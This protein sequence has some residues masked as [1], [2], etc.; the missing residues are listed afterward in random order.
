MGVVQHRLSHDIGK[1]KGYKAGE[2]A[3]DDKMS[4]VLLHTFHVHLQSCQEHNII[5]SHA[6]EQFERVVAL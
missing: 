4:G 1:Q 6:S 3:E 5:E 2:Q